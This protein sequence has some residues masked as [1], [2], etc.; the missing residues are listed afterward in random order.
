MNPI[1][2]T[3]SLLR[4]AAVNTARPEFSPK[5]YARIAGVLYLYIILAGIFVELFVRGKLVMSGDA[6]ATAAN[7]MAHETRWRIAFSAEVLWLACAVA[8]TMI[9]YVLMRVVNRN[10]ALMGAFFALMSIAVEAMSTLLHFAPVLVL[11]GSG[12]LKAL[13]TQQLNALALLSANLFEYGFGIS[14]VFFGF[15]EL[16]RGYLIFRSGF[17]PKFLGV[18]VIVSGVSYLTNSFA[19]FLSPRIAGMIFPIFVP[20][21]GVPEII[22]TA[23]LLV[24]GLNEVK[25]QDRASRLYAFDEPVR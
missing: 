24:V 23:W 22:L 15:E 4:R 25:W 8:L 12:Y 17:F 10:I 1:L 2:R 13:D 18:L 21:A 9:F 11:G 16:F 5:L 19:L 3:T 7:I 6:A 20:L 14:L